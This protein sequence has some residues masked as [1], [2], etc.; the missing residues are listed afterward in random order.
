MIESILKKTGP[1]LSGELAER[2]MSSQIASNPS[3]ARKIIQR[4]RNSK[5]ILS[6]EPV[7]FENSYLC[8]LEQHKKNR[9]APKIRSLLDS[10]PP[11]K[12]ALSTML[13]NKGFITKGQFAKVTGSGPWSVST[14][15][16][17]RSSLTLI[18]QAEKLEL[19]EP[20]HGFP[21]MYRI[22]PLFGR[23]E[24]QR[25]GFIRRLEIDDALLPQLC[26]WLQHTYLLSPNARSV[27]ENYREATEFNQHWWDIHGSVFIGRAPRK[28][29]KADRF[30]VADFVGYRQVTIADVDS[31]L[32]RVSDLRARWKSLSIFPVFIGER[33]SSDAWSRLRTNGIA[34]VVN[35]D[36]FGKH[37]DK[38]LKQFQAA[39]AA[40][41]A[42]EINVAK[43]TDFLESTVNEDLGDGVL[44]NM[45]GAIFELV[46]ALYYKN[47]G[48]DVTLQKSVRKVDDKNAYLEI[49]VVASKLAKHLILVECKGRTKNSLESQTEIDRHFQQRLPAACDEFGWN[50]TE[51]YSRVD[52]VFV[53][54]GNLPDSAK[55]NRK[56]R[57][58]G[59][60][61]IC[62]DRN[63]F[64]DWL[65]AN[66][67]ADLLKIVDRFF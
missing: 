7:T 61:Q 47:E 45:K 1:L 5:Q 25:N 44:G 18:Q 24:I 14:Q 3:S 35:A 21:D 36:V 16:G 30:L 23:P 40:K 38:L 64:L 17:R 15:A 8:Y 10:R 54:T 11:L 51:H 62:I 57:E 39:L 34:A 66:D 53:T 26:E 41:T 67:Y 6:T 31:F 32:S 4:A 28:V 37:L 43:L 27:R 12:R 13:A 9:Y 33:F 56:L 65:R 2:I 59:T 58:S 63:G 49:D 60:N 42:E 52:A 46:V 22:G 29:S 20:V 19:L 55:T 48:Y 50:A